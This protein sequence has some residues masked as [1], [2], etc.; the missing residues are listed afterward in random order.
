MLSRLQRLEQTCRPRTSGWQGY[1]QKQRLQLMRRLT[2]GT[3][4]RP[5][6]RPRPCRCAVSAPAPATGVLTQGLTAGRPALRMLT[7]L[8]VL[9]LPDHWGIDM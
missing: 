5:R 8:L 1:W 3:A 2:C 7:I 6:M 4:L 9:T